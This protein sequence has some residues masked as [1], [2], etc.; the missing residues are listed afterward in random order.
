MVRWK[1]QAPRGSIGPCWTRPPGPPPARRTGAPPQAGAGARAVALGRPRPAPACSAIRP[2]RG[3][4][5][6]R[7]LRCIPP[8]LTLSHLVSPCLTLSHLVFVLS[9]LVSLVPRIPQ[10]FA[11]AARPGRSAGGRRAPAG[12][13]PRPRRA[14]P[15]HPRASRPAWKKTVDAR[16]T[17]GHDEGR[18]RPVR[19]IDTCDSPHGKTQIDFGPARV[20]VPP[21]RSPC[22]ASVRPGRRRNEAP[23]PPSFPL[24]PSAGRGTGGT[25]PGCQAARRPGNNR[26]RR[27]QATAV[28]VPPGALRRGPSLTQR[29]TDGADACKANVTYV[30]SITGSNGSSPIA[31][32][33]RRQGPRGGTRPD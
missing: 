26:K 4:F 6:A 31:L 17:R 9:R 27:G 7:T 29:T 10:K 21:W 25:G 14:C 11:G 22:P 19:I 18:A 23:T 13:R 33:S 3:R 2:P 1:A 5:R 12:T 16:N 32:A 28:T 24:R 15:G 8:C 30:I 20:P